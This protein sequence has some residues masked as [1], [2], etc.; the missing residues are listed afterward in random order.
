[1]NLDRTIDQ[2]QLAQLGLLLRKAPCALWNN[3][4][5]SLYLC[6][7]SISSER[8]SVRE[9]FRRNLHMRSDL[10]K[11]NISISTF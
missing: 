4:K 2:E 5:V 10:P 11:E 6:L 3:E 9:K 8:A 7:P 1:M